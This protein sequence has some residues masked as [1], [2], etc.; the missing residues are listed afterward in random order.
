M[1]YV[2]VVLLV[3]KDIIGLKATNEDSKNYVLNKL[4]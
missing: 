3:Q 2:R 4:T 1:I